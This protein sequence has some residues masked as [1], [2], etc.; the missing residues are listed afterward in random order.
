MKK[1][2]LFIYLLLI[3]S[4]LISSSFFF[5]NSKKGLKEKTAVGLKALSSRDQITGGAKEVANNE[6]IGVENDV[7]IAADLAVE[8]KRSFI[9]KLLYE[10]GNRTI[11]IHDAVERC[12]NL[13]SQQ[14]KEQAF[15]MLG[16]HFA[17]QNGLEL[18]DFAMTMTPSANRD[19]MLSTYLQLHKLQSVEDFD[20]VQDWYSQ[21]GYKEDKEMVMANVSN[22][23]RSFKYEDALALFH[24]PYTDDL[25]DI[26]IERIKGRAVESLVSLTNANNFE[27]IASKVSHDFDIDTRNKYIEIL[28]FNMPI[29]KAENMLPYVERI[30]YKVS[31]FLLNVAIANSSIDAKKTFISII[32]IAKKF[33][34][35][36]AVAEA[37][38][39]WIVEDPMEFS[40]YF[41]NKLSGS[42]YSKVITDVMVEY[43]ENKGDLVGA[44]QWRNSAN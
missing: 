25:D 39:A 5:V 28:A 6:K 13:E 14:E 24:R 11:N 21:T 15:V 29:E 37:T 30:D 17:E 16:K 8:I 38:K 32:D 27:A 35:E 7:N 1:K 2:L 44:E 4:S 31:D 10:L 19:R 9:D 34:A 22:L 26:A 36:K 43:L 3:F 40:E 12:L 20:L 42:K 23:M 41:I 18:L 33:P